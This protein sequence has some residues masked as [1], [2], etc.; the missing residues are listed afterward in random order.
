[1][2][3]II[4]RLSSGYNLGRQIAQEPQRNRLQELML[5]REQQALQSAQQRQQQ[6]QQLGQRQQTEFDQSQALRNIGISLRA[7]R[8]LK[9]LQPEQRQQ[10]LQGMLPEME[11]FG[12]DT[13]RLSEAD[14][15][16][17][18]LAGYEASLQAF[19]QDPQRAMTEFQR[20]NLELQER[21]LEQQAEL[22]PAQRERLKLQEMRQDPEHQKALKEAEERGKLQAK[23]D[24]GLEYERES[25]LVKNEVNKM[26]SQ[27]GQANKLAD[28]DNALNI[29]IPDDNIDVLDKIYGKGEAFYPDALRSQKGLDALAARDQLV[30]MLQLGARGELKGQGPITEGEQNILSRA[31]TMLGNPS[32]SPELAKRQVERAVEILRSSAGKSPKKEG[33]QIM[34][35][36]QGNKAIVYPDGTFE[37]IQ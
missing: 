14:L 16:D 33:G 31:A 24:L 27:Q 6:A 18:G 37:E 3:N 23:L 21:R 30:S 8:S 4:D 29:L 26:I 28:V 13:S 22:T 1:M 19:A 7:I 5:Q 20:R 9:S 32:I 35:D 25:A 34:V 15:S 11:R 10:A 36:A 17:Q 12:I 2:V